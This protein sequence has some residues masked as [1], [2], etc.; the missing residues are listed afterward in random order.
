MARAVA[1]GGTLS[2]QLVANNRKG[3]SVGGDLAA[4]DVEMAQLL[5]D[6]AGSDRLSGPAQARLQFLGVGNDVDAI[7]RSL[8]GTGAISME[9][10]RLRGLDLNALMNDGQST[11]GTTVFDS[12]TAGFTIAGGTLTNDDLLVSLPNYR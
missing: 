7:M 11:G 3:L 8:S 6:L 1:F 9:Q 5:G 10:G 4:R 12:L 2:G